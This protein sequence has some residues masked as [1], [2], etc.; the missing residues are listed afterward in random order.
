MRI[1]AASLLVALAL[2]SSAKAQFV[3]SRG[4]GY[5]GYGGGYRGYGGGYGNYGGFGSYGGYSPIR[6][7]GYY[8]RGYGAGYS[9][10]AYQAPFAPGTL[11]PAYYSPRARTVNRL[12][13]FGGLLGRV[14]RSRRGR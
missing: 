7:G 14:T 8:S 3:V 12:G 13:S 9:P 6:S 2:G 11:N 4:L 10:Y 1:F 5:G